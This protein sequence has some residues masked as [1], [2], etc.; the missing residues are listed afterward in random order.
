MKTSWCKPKNKSSVNL[1]DVITNVAHDISEC[2]KICENLK[3]SLR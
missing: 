1:K 2:G 3:L